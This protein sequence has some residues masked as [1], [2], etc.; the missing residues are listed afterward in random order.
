MGVVFNIIGLIISNISLHNNSNATNVILPASPEGNTPFPQE[1]EKNLGAGSEG[2]PIVWTDNMKQLGF[3][4]SR[5]AG[6]IRITELK[7]S[8]RHWQVDKDGDKYLVS[9]K[10]LP[11]IL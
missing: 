3:A 2:S 10:E 4:F 6:S 7:S 1:M 11:H 9:A 8:L 5:P